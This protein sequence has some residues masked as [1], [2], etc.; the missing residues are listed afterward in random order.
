MQRFENF[1]QI[2]VNSGDIHLAHIIQQ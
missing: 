2:E 1:E